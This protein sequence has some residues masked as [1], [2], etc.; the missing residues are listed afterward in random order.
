M[1]SK[2]KTDYNGIAEEYTSLQNEFYGKNK[3]ESRE[4]LYSSIDFSLKSKQ[5]LDAGCGF[6]KDL[7]YFK[8]MGAEVYGIDSSQ[9][10]VELAKV[11]NPNVEQIRIS[12]FEKTEFE[13]NFFDVIISRYSFNHSLDLECVFREMHRILKQNGYLI[14]I[15]GHPIMQ[16]IASKKNEYCSGEIAKVSLF[17]KINIKEPTHTFSEYLSRFVL[18]NFEI[19]SFIEGPEKIREINLD[20][21][22]PDFVF[23]KLRKK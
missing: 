18:G 15:A 6:G 17:G 20:E 14:F 5:V 9:K 10:M 12:S 4:A 21:K 2:Q 7:S 1:K 8:N 23:F 19:L 16:F 22:I 13:N 3:N 11:N